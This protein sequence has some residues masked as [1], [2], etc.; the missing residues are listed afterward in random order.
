MSDEPKVEV[1]SEPGLKRQF[2]KGRI[3]FQKMNRRGRLSAAL[4]GG[5]A[6]VATIVTLVVTGKPKK[7]GSDRVSQFLGVQIPQGTSEDGMVNIPLAVSKSQPGGAPKGVTPGVAFHF[8]GPQLVSRPRN[9]PIPPGSM[10]EATL[11]SGASDGPVKA[12]IK[13]PLIVAGETL[14]DA[15]TVLMGSGQSGDDRLT[16][17]FRKAIFRDGSVAKID[18]QAADGSDK[19]PG[20]KGSRVGYRALKLGAGVGLNFAAGLSQGL[21]STQG[22]GGAVV[23]PPSMRNALLNG[24]ARATLDE[25]QEMMN[26]YRN[27]HPVITV[28]AGTLVWVLFDDGN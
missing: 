1:V 5:V 23:T 19:I 28:S 21:Q 12:E 4:A 27:E 11:I 6:L 8:S 25:G 20:I 13:E 15:G 7:D 10:V 24:A 14:L 17:H 3:T 26:E 16:I 2:G 18:A 22:Q 9:V